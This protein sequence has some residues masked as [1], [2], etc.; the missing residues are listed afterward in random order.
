MNDP[1]PWHCTDCGA[2]LQWRRTTLHCP[3]HGTLC[4]LPAY[5]DDRDEHQ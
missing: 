3:T 1:R 2:R 5:P 4:Q